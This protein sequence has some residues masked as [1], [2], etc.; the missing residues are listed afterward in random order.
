VAPE[1]SAGPPAEP[2]TA[3]AHFR[4]PSPSPADQPSRA[5]P[6]A[7]RVE[8]QG[9]DRFEIVRHVGSGGMGAVYEAHD[10]ERGERVALKTL[11]RVGPLELYLFKNEF[12]SL[13]KIAHPNLVSLHEFFATPEMF[14]FTMQ[15]VEG[16]DLLGWL[17]GEGQPQPDDTAAFVPF[18]EPTAAVTDEGFEALSGSLPSQWALEG[19]AIRL[20]VRLLDADGLARLRPALAQ[21]C[22][23]VDA[24]HSSGRLHRDIKSDNVRLDADGHLLLLDF[25][26]VADQ[27]ETTVLDGRGGTL[28]A[29]TVSYMSPEQARGDELTPASDWYSVGCILYEALIGRPPFD[30]APLEVLKAK[31][32]GEVP[33]PPEHLIADLPADLLR[34][35][36]ELLL[37]EPEGRPSG[38][39]ILAD[40]GFPDDDEESTLSSTFR[41]STVDHD[42]GLVGRESE[43]RALRAALSDVHA[44]Q[45]RAVFVHGGSGMGKTELVSHLLDEARFDG[46]LVVAARCHEREW[47]PHKAIDPIVDRLVRHLLELSTDEVRALV[48]DELPS[49]ARLF[50]VLHRVPAFTFSLA[51]ATVVQEPVE[52]RRRAVLAL[53]DLLRGLGARSPV[54]VFID[55][56]QWADLDSVRILDELLRQRLAAP[57]LLLGAYRDE[58]EQGG[59]V[60]QALGRLVQASRAPSAVARLEVGPLS[61]ADSLALAEAC[62]SRIGWSDH[63]AEMVAAESQGVPFLVSE[64]VRY[65]RASHDGAEHSWSDG[66]TLDQVIRDRVAGLPG[67]A[68]TLLE[69]AALAGRPTPLGLLARLRGV[70]EPSR[71]A[72][73]LESQ[74]L[75]RRLG[76]EGTVDCYNDQIREAL[77]IYSS[78][79]DRH[80]V[81]V[82][83]ADLFCEASDPDAEQVAVHLLEA[84][85]GAR[86]EPW[87]RAA[88]AAAERA[89]AFERAADLYGRAAELQ[90]EPEQRRDLLARRAAELVNAGRGLAA[91]EAYLAA[92]DGAPQQVAWRWTQAAAEQLLR[93]GRLD[94]GRELIV[95]VLAAA[96]I[97]IP[98]T[99]LGT[100]AAFLTRRVALSIRGLRFDEVDEQ[101]LTQLERGRLDIALSAAEVL[102][103][104]DTL[105]GALMHARS[106]QMALAAGEPLR[107]VRALTLEAAFAA[108]VGGTRDDR[109]IGVLAVA[110]ELAARLEDPR[111]SAH[112]LMI[113]ALVDF[114]AGRW[115]ESLGHARAGVAVLV[116]ECRGM[117]YELG[118]CRAYEL[119]ALAWLGRLEEFSATSDEWSAQARDRGDL[120]AELMGM[121]GPP[122]HPDAL[123]GDLEAAELAVVALRERWPDPRFGILDVYA[124]RSLAELALQR[125][126]PERALEL[127][128]ELNRKLFRSELKRVAVL[129]AVAWDVLGRCLVAAAPQGLSRPLREASR[130]A[131]RL[132]SM[133]PG[134][135]V[136]QAASVRAG[137]AAR[138]GDGEEVERQLRL[139]VVRAVEAGMMLHAAAARHRLGRL[140]P[141]SDGDRMAHVAAAW[142]AEAGVERPAGIVRCLFPGAGASTDAT[143]TA[144]D[145]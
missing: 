47:M 14:F 98:R 26:L 20:P 143:G 5:A 86:A 144:S 48:P 135:G 124:N 61:D 141:V 101:A 145:Q 6:A 138:R 68:R 126:E 27:G 66:L 115:E 122:R 142:F 46:A 133:G 44:G 95:E 49:L 31:A 93:A 4:T 132:D 28:V 137:V 8:F 90:E 109:A 56:L 110:E 59:D 3:P 67:I 92:A 74:H 19:S 106:L 37:P 100:V 87:V 129:R 40:L 30:G 21:L 123:A 9:T 83:L 10:R 73:F 12:R 63:M 131:R 13:S 64:L 45:T 108:A 36:R 25:G 114:Q 54:V 60:L 88:A 140:L 55:D 50:P 116:G 7:G 16:V 111:A 134:W 77:T 17:R 105:A 103:M 34:L 79:D 1:D 107:V 72:V 32:E 82:G 69:T 127:A 43:Q 23:A 41:L 57:L 29:G 119:G 15:F 91:A 62:L 11:H 94:R 38:A 128:R 75:L 85:E 84:R 33:T 71:V 136:V 65:L 80:A 18:I 112:C 52:L 42:V 97:R 118:V 139:A 89:L 102:G 121:L 2:G 120:N 104:T 70:E 53:A 24:I 22:S 76:G 81:H 96:G 130:C 125:D 35:C 51:G 78:F 39:E 99:E 117:S 113:R 58:E